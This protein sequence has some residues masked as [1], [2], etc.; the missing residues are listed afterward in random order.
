[1]LYLGFMTLSRSIVRS[2]GFI[3]RWDNLDVITLNQAYLHLPRN[4]LGKIE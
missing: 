2:A 4:H 3:R 1:M